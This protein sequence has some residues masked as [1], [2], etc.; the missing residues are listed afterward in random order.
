MLTEMTYLDTHPIE[1]PVKVSQNHQSKEND[2][3]WSVG[4]KVP[5]GT[6]THWY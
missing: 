2:L 4:R 5:S 3:E 6:A 1:K